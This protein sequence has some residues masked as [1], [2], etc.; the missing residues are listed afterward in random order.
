M[1]GAVS[2]LAATVKTSF[3]ESWFAK[4]SK[5]TRRRGEEAV[6]RISS[7][8]TSRHPE[9]GMFCRPEERKYIE[10]VMAGEGR[11]AVEAN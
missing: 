4:D 9:S 11:G 10:H 7:G 8:L 6:P 5:G 2:G 1:V 3:R